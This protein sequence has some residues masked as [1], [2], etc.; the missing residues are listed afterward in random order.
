MW[1]YRNG[2]GDGGSSCGTSGVNCEVGGVS[3]SGGGGGGGV[4]VS[5]GGGGVGGGFFLAEAF[6][7]LLTLWFV[8]SRSRHTQRRDDVVPTS[9]YPKCLHGRNFVNADQGRLFLVFF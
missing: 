8:I 5:G 3:G 4:G 2:G 7:D 6:E 9:V 1:R